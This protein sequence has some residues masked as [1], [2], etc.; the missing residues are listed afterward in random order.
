MP[1]TRLRS[2]PAWFAT[3]ALAAAASGCG[4]AAVET[5]GFGTGGSGCTLAN[6]ASSFA[7]GVP[8]QFVA[9]FAPDLPAGSSVVISLSQDGKDLPDYAG[10][11]HLDVARN[12]V[13]GGWRSLNAGHYR[14]VLTSSSDTGMPALAG[15]FDVTP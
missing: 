2:V 6:S 5:I 4:P 10:T 14:V 8:V 12:C 15:E 7:A 1:G 3:L 13:G 9:T 11:V